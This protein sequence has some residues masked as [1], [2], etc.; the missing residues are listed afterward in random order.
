M[1]PMQG[2]DNL[3]Q[4]GQEAI[5]ERM[6]HVGEG[7][8][9]VA[10]TPAPATANRAPSVLRVNLTGEEPSASIAHARILGGGTSNRPAYP[11]DNSSFP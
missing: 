5:E 8:V 10:D 1:L 3:Y 2:S 9:T 11:T 7:K 6:V 4:V